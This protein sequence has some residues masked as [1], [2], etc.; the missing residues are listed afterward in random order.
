VLPHISPNIQL[1]KGR[2][3]DMGARN[4]DYSD[5]SFPKF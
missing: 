4:I 2:I 5:C 3:I 1:V